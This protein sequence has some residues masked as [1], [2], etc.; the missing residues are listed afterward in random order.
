MSVY[1]NNAN[2]AKQRGVTLSMIHKNID[3]GL[4]KL[5][6]IT[7]RSNNN[8]INAVCTDTLNDV[9]PES[10][11]LI[12]EAM[13][14]I[15]DAVRRMKLYVAVMF[16]IASNIKTVED[17]TSYVRQATDIMDDPDTQVAINQ[18]ATNVNR[19]L[20]DQADEST[21]RAFTDYLTC[22]IGK[23]VETVEQS[24]DDKKHMELVM[25]LM[26]L[27]FTTYSVIISDPKI[28]EMTKMIG[29]IFKEHGQRVIEGAQVA[30]NNGRTSGGGNSNLGKLKKAFAGGAGQ[31]RSRS[32][33]GKR[34][35]ASDR[36]GS[37]ATRQQ[38]RKSSRDDKRKQQNKGGSTMT[39]EMEK[40]KVQKER[41]GGD[42]G[43][44]VERKQ[45]Q[46]QNSPPGSARKQSRQ[47][48]RK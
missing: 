23:I 45:K 20:K 8:A 15:P 33:E 29:K 39:K 36:N 18:M 32:M 26:D 42:S 47:P 5:H 17:A 6:S 37:E 16:A 19:L 48:A 22:L 40:K 9:S 27:M 44:K 31:Q 43:R 24:L 3:E 12:K 34:S 25:S 35:K 38:S 30:L 7:Q 21:F 13:K 1:N 41:K 46:K 2:V 28:A 14:S 4:N 10:R 11:A